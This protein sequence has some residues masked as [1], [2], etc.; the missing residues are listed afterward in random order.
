MLLANVQAGRKDCLVRSAMELKPM[1]PEVSPK[2]WV[3]FYVKNGSVVEVELEYKQAIEA[4]VYIQANPMD[5]KKE[6]WSS[7]VCDDLAVDIKRLIK[8]IRKV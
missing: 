4:R 8:E 7:V 5:A 6:L 3:S 1:D 2:A